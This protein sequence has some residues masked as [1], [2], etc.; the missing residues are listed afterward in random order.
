[1]RDYKKIQINSRE[2]TKIICNR[3]NKEIVVKNGVPEEEVL[4]I[5]KRWGYFSH[6]DG[7]L[8]RFD[9]CEECYDAWI[10]SFQI[11]VYEEQELE[12]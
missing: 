11:P 6:K 2:L 4:T 5:E 10:S 9:L 3:C 8:H 7:E 12:C 1:M